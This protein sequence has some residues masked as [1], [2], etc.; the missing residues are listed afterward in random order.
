MPPR[1]LTDNIIANL[2]P[3]AARYAIPDPKLAGH[4]VRVSPSGAKSFVAVTRD[5]NG[6]QVWHTIGTTQLYKL[7][8]ARERAHTAMRAIQGGESR[9]GP[10]SFQ[11]VAENWLKRHVQQKG[12]RS[13]SEI[14]RVLDKQIFPAWADREF[15]SIRRGDVAKLL[16]DIEDNHGPVAADSALAHLSRI[17]NWYVARRE[18][19]VSPVVKGMRRTNPR[20]RA[21]DRILSDD[22]IHTVWKAAE[23][24]G[25]YGALVQLLLLTGQ[26]RAKVATIRWGDI[27]EDGIWTI[28]AE[29]RERGNAVE[30][31]LPDSALAIIKAQPRFASVP[32]VFA[33]RSGK[34]FSGF[35]KAKESFDAKLPEMKTWTLHD[36]RRTARSLMSRAG[37]F[38]HIAERVLGHA[39]SGVEGI[40]DRHAYMAEKAQALKMLAGLI[41]NILRGDSDKKVH[42]LRR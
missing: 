22:E 1:T 16:D 17:F 35:S 30:L 32:F 7:E 3:K 23:A 21:R 15:T 11:T 19:Y 38:P 8:E 27:S 12:L 25:T 10:E 13:E 31:A 6:K 18:D 34:H 42:R 2:K 36:L 28:P 39:I 9:E 26:R 29:D 33:G 37:V 24:N 40:Y 41:E 20:E 14:R 4:Y 5:P